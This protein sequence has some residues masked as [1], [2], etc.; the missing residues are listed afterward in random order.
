[1]TGDAAIRDH[2]ARLLAWEDAHVGIRGRGRRRSRPEVRG[3]QP[4]GLHSPWQLHGAPADRPARHPRFL[5]ERRPTKEMQLAGGLL[6]AGRRF[7]RRPPR[8]TT[9]SRSSGRTGRRSSGSP[10]IRQ[11]VL[12]ARIPHGTG[13]TY[14]AGAA[15][16]RGSLGL[17]RRADRARPAAAGRVDAAVTVTPMIAV[18][19]L[20]KTYGTTTAVTHLSFD[21]TPGEILGLI[22]PNGAGK[23]STLRCIAGI[24]RPSGGIVTLC[25]P[26]HRAGPGRG[27]A[28]ACVR[29]R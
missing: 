21:V 15:A 11:I 8:G 13:Q 20:T 22:G 5:P 3:R 12:G 18:T 26:R 23:T 19:N 17:P 4:S 2:L 9:A 16:D 25:R 6:A 24:H 29:R 27:Q 28:G 1:M 7:P 10:P 14:L